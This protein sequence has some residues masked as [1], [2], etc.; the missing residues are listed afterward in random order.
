MALQQQHTQPS[1]DGTSHLNL[2]AWLPD[3][4][5]STAS[6]PP[7]PLS[8]APSTSR[9]HPLSSSMEF[10]QWHQA[11]CNSRDPSRDLAATPALDPGHASFKRSR[12]EEVSFLLNLGK[13]PRYG[14]DAAVPALSS[15]PVPGP[16]RCTSTYTSPLSSLWQQQLAYLAAS[17]AQGT[18]L[19]E[20]HSISVSQHEQQ[21]GVDQPRRQ[22]GSCRIAERGEF[23]PNVLLQEQLVAA[24]TEADMQRRKAA[25]L[26]QQLEVMQQSLDEAR[27]GFKAAEEEAA[28]LRL[29]LRQC[30][31]KLR[32]NAEGCEGQG[33]N[34]FSNWGPADDAAS[35]CG[36]SQG[37]QNHGQEGLCGH[38]R[39]S[40]ATVLLIPC[41]H[42]ILCKKCA[43]RT[44]SCPTCEEAYKAVIHLRDV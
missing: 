10:H 20:D 27:T 15:F 7:P 29:Y 26:E 11:S 38:C 23:G 8:R 30:V 3:H 36:G 9:N 19:S 25:I 6:P 34:E 43:A 41:R 40:K 16:V 22:E 4:L 17:G 14:E 44:Q 31:S 1:L 13:R 12:S 39:S 33:E 18:S 42:L 37:K 21:G 35:S 2:S 28:V 5:K 32:R 24:Q